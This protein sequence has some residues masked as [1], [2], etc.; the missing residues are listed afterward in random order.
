MQRNDLT[1]RIEDVT[2]RLASA[3]AA[4]SATAVTGITREKVALTQALK[5][6]TLSEEECRAL[7]DRMRELKERLFDLLAELSEAPERETETM[8]NITKMHEAVTAAL[9]TLSPDRPSNGKGIRVSGLKQIG[10]FFI[11]SFAGM[12]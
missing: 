11:A 4:R 2:A 7:P 10:N 8:D 12:F 3:K 9:S 1:V 6:I 5:D